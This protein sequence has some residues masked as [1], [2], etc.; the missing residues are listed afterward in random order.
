VAPLLG[1]TGLGYLLVESAI[2]LANPGDSSTGTSVLGVGM[3]LVI[4]I[5]FALIGLV[6]M[7]GWWAFGD[8]GFFTRPGLEAVPPKIADGTA[9][10][11][12][13]PPL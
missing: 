10:A 4:A 3:P 12:E 13:L 9:T 5:G 1:A 11:V 6:L 2:R 7:A 8:R